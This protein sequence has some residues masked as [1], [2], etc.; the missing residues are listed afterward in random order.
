MHASL[1]HWQLVSHFISVATTF[2]RPAERLKVFSG[3]CFFPDLVTKLAQYHH[4][5]G[6]Q[7]GLAGFV[8][9]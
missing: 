5:E 3:L 1:D 9:N 6:L 7:A 4:N 8:A 2:D